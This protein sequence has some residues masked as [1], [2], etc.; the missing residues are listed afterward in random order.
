[1]IELRDIL[2]NGE[3]DDIKLDGMTP[4]LKL[5]VKPGGMA[6]VVQVYDLDG[7]VH[8]VAGMEWLRATQELMFTLSDKDSG[9]T[10]GM[11]QLKPDGT[12]T[13]GNGMVQHKIATTNEVHDMIRSYDV[14][15]SMVTSG[16]KPSI[17]ECITAFKTLPNMDWSKDDRFYIDSTNKGKLNLVKYL[18]NGDT[19]ERGTNYTFWLEALTEAV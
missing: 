9:V 18:A 4:S 7:A 6:G 13:V 3:L 17:S 14:T 15:V 12:A 11:F 8:L 1:M 10:K 2:K 5:G 19:D 16:N